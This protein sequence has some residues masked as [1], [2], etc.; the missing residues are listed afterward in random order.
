MGH[1]RA[2]SLTFPVRIFIHVLPD[3][4]CSRI[5]SLPDALAQGTQGG[6]NLI[7]GKAPNK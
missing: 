2:Y 5:R 1:R 6:Q 3:I 4:G 7:T